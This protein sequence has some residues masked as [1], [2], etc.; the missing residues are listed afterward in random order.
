MRYAMPAL[1]RAL[2]DAADDYALMLL[3]RAAADAAPP[4]MRMACAYTAR[5]GMRERHSKCAADRAARARV[6]RKKMSVMQ[7]R[8]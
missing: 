5:G 3:T 6:P 2:F 1:T 4:K 7:W 8:A